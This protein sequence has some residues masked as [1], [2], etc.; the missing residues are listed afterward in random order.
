MVF[1]VVMFNLF[2]SIKLSSDK[3]S[4]NNQ[5]ECSD[6]GHSSF[7]YVPE[8][9][10]ISVERSSGDTGDFAVANYVLDRIRREK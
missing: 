3:S 5:E 2:P 4:G 6:E 9:M 7:M 10:E 8:G 1:L